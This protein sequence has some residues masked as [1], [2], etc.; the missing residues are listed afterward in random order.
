VVALEE[1]AALV[2]PEEVVV[3]V[4]R[5]AAEL[6]LL[7]HPTLLNTPTLHFL[8]QVEVPRWSSFLLLS[9][10]F[11]EF[12]KNTELFNYVLSLGL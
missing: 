7:I 3:V 8:S 5:V 4:E 11:F 6:L 1:T 12:F 2:D 10:C 9:S